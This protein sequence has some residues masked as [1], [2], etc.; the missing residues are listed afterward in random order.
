MTK[1]NK[2]KK[3]GIPVDSKAY[4]VILTILSF[5]CLFTIAM[6]AALPDEARETATGFLISQTPLLILWLFMLIKRIL[7]LCRNHIA[8]KPI[9][10]LRTFGRWFSRFIRPYHFGYCKAGDDS[11]PIEKQ[12]SAFRK[13]YA[14]FYEG[15]DIR[16]NVTQFYQHMLLLHRKR[17]QHL[18]ISL[19]TD[20]FRMH[21][22]K[23]AP[24]MG[25][26]IPDGKFR[27]IHAREYLQCRQSLSC[28]N[29]KIYSLKQDITAEYDIIG[30]KSQKA[31]A[32]SL[33]IIC[34]N[35]G[36]A[37]TAEQLLTGCPYCDS[38]FVIE[39][40]SDRV[41]G[42][43]MG[44]D[45]EQKTR[46]TGLHI[47]SAVNRCAL[48]FTMISSLGFLSMFYEVFTVMNAS[49]RELPIAV[50]LTISGLLFTFVIAILAGHIL[51]FPFRILVHFLYKKWREKRSEEARIFEK[52]QQLLKQIHR[53]DPE[54]SLNSFF[55]N[56][57]NKL[58]AI[59]FADTLHEVHVF[60]AKDV[61]L[62]LPKYRDIADCLFGPMELL[63]CQMEG[64]QQTMKIRVSLQLLYWTG[65]AIR[66]ETEHLE[67]TL[68]KTTGY[69]S[70]NPFGI[71]S[72]RCSHCGAPI[73]LL[74]GNVCSYCGTKFDF[75]HVD[76]YIQSYK[77]ISEETAC[78]AE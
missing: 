26:L 3:S 39:E 78:L 34:P 56:V 20:C 28:G 25:S 70:K 58:A 41:C 76:W 1:Q 52:N 35:C 72:P 40:L 18:G 45:Y 5:L 77:R 27:H 57:R 53:V 55:S 60:A 71:Y 65:V 48:A 69:T 50:A 66:E 47:D 64:N 54:F 19:H 12:L 24:V 46:L 67:L 21:F 9:Q 73:D 59:H 8:P 38:Y 7:Y 4:T 74:E 75:S 17:L 16:K 15:K 31:D 32:K 14:A 6:V 30:I 23:E 22:D 13:E 62:Y 33:T 68:N 49:A 36:A 2:P 29:K 63:S 11:S 37:S 44:P 43:S 51:A 10:T 42:M 61:S